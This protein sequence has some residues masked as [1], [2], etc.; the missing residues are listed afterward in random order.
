MVA[1]AKAQISSEPSSTE[2][3]PL[4]PAG[5]VPTKG[6]WGLALF[7]KWA[8]PERPIT[9]KKIIQVGELTGVPYFTTIF[10][11]SAT[12]VVSGLGLQL[13]VWNQCD[14]LSKIGKRR[15]RER[16]SPGMSYPAT[17]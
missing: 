7:D 9:I 11:F 5:R 3:R 16:G 17:S 12:L 10:S 1:G 4:W 15:G 6:T 2:L 13:S 14:P 8:T